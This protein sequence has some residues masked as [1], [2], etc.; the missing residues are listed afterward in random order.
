MSKMKLLSSFQLAT[1]FY[2]NG[3]SIVVFGSVARWYELGLWLNQ[4]PIWI[5]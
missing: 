5:K 4:V 3:G 2:S 1:R